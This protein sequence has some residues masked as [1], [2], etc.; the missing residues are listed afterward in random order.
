MQIRKKMQKY[1]K[2]FHVGEKY[3][4]MELENRD[5]IQKIQTYNYG[6]ARATIPLPVES[7]NNGNTL[8]YLNSLTPKTLFGDATL[9]A[10]YEKSK[11]ACNLTVP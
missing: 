10:N 5:N 6:N 7:L 9:G 3:S 2:E 8:R 1:N 4:K 11:S